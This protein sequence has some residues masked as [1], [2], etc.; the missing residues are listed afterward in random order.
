M[1]VHV[2]LFS[3]PHRASTETLR[4]RV[5]QTELNEVQN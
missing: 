1:V 3:L 5:G 4:L 2:T